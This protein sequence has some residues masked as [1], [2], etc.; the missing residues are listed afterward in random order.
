MFI[1]CI[2]FAA[3]SYGL[4]DLYDKYDKMEHTEGTVTYL[5]TEK[6][7]RHRKIY[8]KHTAIIEYYTGRYKT[9]TSMQVYNP[10]ISQGQGVT[11]WFNPQLPDE[12][13]LPS[14]QGF[15]WSSLWIFSIICLFLGF[16]TSKNK[17]HKN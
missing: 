2:T 4:F 5:K 15:V 9:R 12:V 16:V 14:E 6:T 13:V 1:G 8:Y 10:F 11:V 7:Y 3:G 17:H